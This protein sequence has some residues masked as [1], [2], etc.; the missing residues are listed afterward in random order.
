MINAQTALVF[1]LVFCPVQTRNKFSWK[2]NLPELRSSPLM[3]KLQMST[4]A[5]PKSPHSY[6]VTAKLLC[7]E[8]LR[9][10][11]PA[12]Q[13]TLQSSPTLLYREK[14]QE[15]K[16]KSCH[17]DPGQS[18]CPA[19][20]VCPP[21]EQGRERS[22][23]HSQHQCMPQFSPCIHCMREAQCS[24]PK[25]PVITSSPPCPPVPAACRA[26]PVSLGP[27]TSASL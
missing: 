14:P 16:M 7:V 8:F 27:G 19:S 20:E 12:L 25:T 15:A 22:T 2:V 10:S 6:E 24:H 1:G 21:G 11:V 23:A 4:P 18:T 5:S 3:Q 13:D 17:S 9:Q 26:R